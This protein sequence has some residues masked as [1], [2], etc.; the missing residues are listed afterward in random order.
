MARKMTY[1]IFHTTRPLGESWT[2]G[3]DRRAVFV[4]AAPLAGAERDERERALAL[5]AEGWAPLINPGVQL[6]R[7]AGIDVTPKMMLPDVTHRVLVEHA[8]RYSATMGDAIRA[9][10]GIHTAYGFPK[11]TTWRWTDYPRAPWAPQSAV[12][13]TELFWGRLPAGLVQWLALQP[14]EDADWDRHHVLLGTP[15]LEEY[16]RRGYSL[17]PWRRHGDIAVLAE[18]H[19][20][21]KGMAFLW[22][23]AQ[24][25][26]GR[27]ET[28]EAV[29][30]AELEERWETIELLAQL[31]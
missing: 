10:E 19:K 13:V 1:T 11:K 20:L 15:V 9:Y 3:R 5:R 17:A 4:D 14:L 29:V 25:P 22:S 8:W 18:R 7:A 28:P 26:L 27:N 6:L 30:L 21:V 12:R 24:T 23:M 31:T 2:E 16:W